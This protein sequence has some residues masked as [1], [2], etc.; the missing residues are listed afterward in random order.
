VGEELERDLTLGEGLRCEVDLTHPAT[1][2]ERLD[3]VAGDLGA[4]PV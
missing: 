2:D 3:A 1:G 4:D